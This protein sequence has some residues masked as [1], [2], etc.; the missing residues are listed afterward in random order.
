VGDPI[1]ASS[2]STRPD[3]RDRGVRVQGRYRSS[4]PDPIALPVSNPDEHQSDT[5][6]TFDDARVD[7]ER[8]WLVFLLKRTEADFQAWRE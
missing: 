8:A 6:A 1:I 4:L 2:R 3:H 5:A 7:F